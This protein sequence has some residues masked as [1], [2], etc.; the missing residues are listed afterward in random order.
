MPAFCCAIKNSELLIEGISNESKI[1]APHL[2]R[3]FVIQHN[4]KGQLN[5]ELGIPKWEPWRDFDV[6]CSKNMTWVNF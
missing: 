1:F 4:F 5:E 3:G 2:R 6:D